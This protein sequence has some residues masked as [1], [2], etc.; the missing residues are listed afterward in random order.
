MQK[1]NLS[2]PGRIIAPG[3][4]RDSSALDR[5]AR[6]SN[7]V[8]PVVGEGAGASGARARA[9]APANAR[10]EID[11]APRRRGRRRRP[12]RRRA[13]PV[14]ATARR[15]ATDAPAGNRAPRSTAREPTLERTPPGFDATPRAHALA[16]RRE[17]SAEDSVERAGQGD[18]LPRC[19]DGERTAPRGNTVIV[20]LQWRHRYRRART[21]AVAGAV[22]GVRRPAQ[23]AIA[24]PVSPES[25]SAPPAGATPRH[26]G[27]SCDG[28]HA[29]TL[30]GD[31]AQFLTSA[32][33]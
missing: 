33:R 28:R 7:G 22:V 14:R 26:I 30:G 25:Q 19:S 11:A 5:G 16:R 27:G 17:R 18:R 31:F 10:A 4:A 20:A 21:T 32:V 3:R 23:L 24:K 29:S 15:G 6:R 2:A 12:S 8:G 13:R 1:S 9:R